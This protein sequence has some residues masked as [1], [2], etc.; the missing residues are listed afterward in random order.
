MVSVGPG[1]EQN[2][3]IC[4]R[5]GA[6]VLTVRAREVCGGT[7]RGHRFQALSESPIRGQVF[8]VIFLLFSHSH[9]V[10]IS[11]WSDRKTTKITF[12]LLSLLSAYIVFLF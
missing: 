2:S 10:A 7:Y 3:G 11:F 12:S 6:L 5:T 1:S 4:V 8:W 9:L